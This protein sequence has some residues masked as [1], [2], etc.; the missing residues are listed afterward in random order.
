MVEFYFRVVHSKLGE[1]I[2]LDIDGRQS[3]CCTAILL[4]SMS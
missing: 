2:G 4:L 3:S 1:Q